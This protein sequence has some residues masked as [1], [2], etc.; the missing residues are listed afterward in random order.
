MLFWHRAANTLKSLILLRG[1]RVR[2]NDSIDFL[3]EHDLGNGTLRF[4]I[5]VQ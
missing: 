2:F 4:C 3:V 1:I 5:D